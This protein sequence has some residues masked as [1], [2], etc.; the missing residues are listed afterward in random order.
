MDLSFLKNNR[1][2]SLFLFSIFI[3]GLGTLPIAL[4]LLRAPSIG[5]EVRY[6]P[7]FYFI[8]HIAF[9]T[10]AFPLGKFADSFGKRR[11][12]TIGLFSALVSYVS[13]MF[14]ESFFGLV[15]SFILFGIYSAATDGVERALAAR[16][17]DE[18]SLAMG[19]GMLNAA[20]GI[21]ALLAGGIG[22]LLWTYV[23]PQATFVYAATLSFVGCVLF[24]FLMNVSFK[25]TK[26]TV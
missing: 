14:V 17:V 9:L 10:A 12:I 6:V 13:L 23:S 22:G 21:S 5:I 19:Q 26:K 7:I 8:Y 18:H 11:I 16:L 24:I 4:L 15:I 25:E 2:F 3:F 1:R 20:V